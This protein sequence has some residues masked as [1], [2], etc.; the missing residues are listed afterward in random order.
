MPTFAP[1]I[2]EV[3]QLVEHNLAKVR[4]AGSSPV[5]TRSFQVRVALRSCR[6]ESC[7]GHTITNKSADGEI[8]RHATLR[9]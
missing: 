5:F 8:G 6:F 7:S 9:G 2:A 1:V 3:A 4:V